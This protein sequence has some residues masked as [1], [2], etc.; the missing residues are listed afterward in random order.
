MSPVTHDPFS[1]AKKL[2]TAAGPVTIYAL[3]ALDK[4]APVSRLPFDILQ[5]GTQS[6]E[7][8][9]R[10]HGDDLRGQ[11]G[12][13]GRLQDAPRLLDGVGLDLRLIGCGDLQLHTGGGVGEQPEPGTDKPEERPLWWDST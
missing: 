12:G 10:D 6:G 1:A 7:H 5:F 8:A 4:H 9:Q 11:R 13:R 3:S 2:D